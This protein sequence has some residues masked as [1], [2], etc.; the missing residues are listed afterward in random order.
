MRLTALLT[1]LAATIASAQAQTGLW[2]DLSGSRAPS[3]VEMDKAV[4]DFARK[5]TRLTAETRKALVKAGRYDQRI[6]FSLPTTLHL[7][8]NGRELGRNGNAPG[9]ISLVF[10]ASGTR[11][12]P[13]TYR[14]LL[15]DIFN[16]AKPTLDIVFGIASEAG[17]VLVKN[18]DAD[19][20]DRDAVA[21]G[22]FVPNNGSG[23]RE[24]RFPVYVS[25]EATAVNFIHTL[26]LAYLGSSNYAFDGFQEGIVRAA[27]MKVVRTSGALPATLDPGLM[28]AALQNTYDVGSFYDWY[29][30]RALGGPLF[31]APNLRDLPL[32]S[33]GSLGGIYL[34]R[35]QMAGSAWQKLLAENPGFLKEFNRRF[36]LNPAIRNDVTALA[37]IGQLALNTVTGVAN[38]KIEGLTFAAWVRRQFIL[39][40]KVTLGPKL[41][42]Q[43][44][45]ITTGLGGTDF[46]V[47]DVS[48]TY[49]ETQPGGNEALLS[50][51]SFPIFWDQ[52]FNRIFPS[53]Q[54]DR[55]D[56]AGAYGSVTPNIPDLNS[57]QPYRCTIDIPVA[58]RIARA[59]VPV[60]SIATT[61]N[62]TENNFYGTVVG[63][64]LTGGTLTV[65]TFIGSTNLGT[66]PVRNFAF[67]TTYAQTAYAGYARLRV[68]ILKGGNVIATRFVN[69]GP[70]PLALDL[71]T[72]ESNV[73]VP[74]LK[75]IQMIG[76]PS[77]PYISSAAELLNLPE[78]Q[79]LAARYDSTRADYALYPEF[80]SIEQGGGYFLRSNVA[81]TLTVEG[82]NLVA[83]IAVALKPGWNMI[84]NP[85]NETTTTNRIQVVRTAEFPKTYAEAAGVDIDST[86]FAFTRGPVDAVTG[87]PET[88]NYVAGTQFEPGKAYYVRCLAPEGA[89]MLFFPSGNILAPGQIKA[90]T[91]W[92]VAATV[93]DNR[94][95]VPVGF[96][97]SN[98][99]ISVVDREDSLLPPRLVGGLYATMEVGNV[100]LYRDLKN[101]SGKE[102]FT[103]RAEGLKP[104]TYYTINLKAERGG[105]RKFNI[106]DYYE[107]VSTPVSLP[108]SFRF[109]ATKTSH[110]FIIT[111]GTS[112][113]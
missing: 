5:T 90:P 58:D 96:G 82:R 46:G 70:G 43:P 3:G 78:N 81:R 72:G 63:S 57:G 22:Y 44:I 59:Y 94:S 32:P 38:S 17:P 42:V 104:G 99:A 33:G 113:F 66:V 67:G 107:F 69:K 12:F 76:V 108:G 50:G 15:Q 36:Y 14:D 85:L 29:N 87:A 100:D 77:Y 103:L 52:A 71:R 19:I 60:G 93:T 9:N 34:L 101:T 13:Q 109:R 61:A 86:F 55:M 26:L 75:G 74:I 110:R 112:G 6:P 80:G 24:I 97:R 91:G 47:F 16:T 48:A 23:G 88:G 8:R 56:I 51:T 18:Y 21:G 73:T 84:S 79:V 35:Y 95:T 62:P 106:R 64:N 98:T 111:E 45:P 27:A 2:L 28:E 37:G 25:P 105:S 41:L 68:E 40:S 10:D 54:E 83:P 11:A 1:C 65:R 30:Q 53:S 102:S 49:F 7:S 39:E 89:T 92:R 31:I 20:G 4:R